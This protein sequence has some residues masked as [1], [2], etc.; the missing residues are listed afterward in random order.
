MVGIRS[1]PLGARPIFRCKI[2]ISFREGEKYC[3]FVRTKS[4][5]RSPRHHDLIGG[6]EKHNLKAVAVARS[7]TFRSKQHGNW[8]MMCESVAIFTPF[9]S[10]TPP[11][12]VCNLCNLMTLHYFL[13]YS[14]V[15]LGYF[16]IDLIIHCHLSVSR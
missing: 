7:V 5:Q 10:G 8:E 16:C 11:W 15:F 2:A 13:R 4:A 6:D 3:L 12:E 9:L 1:F 14:H